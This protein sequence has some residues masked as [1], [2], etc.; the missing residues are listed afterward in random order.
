MQHVTEV[1]IVKEVIGK[2]ECDK[3]H[4]IFDKDKDIFEFQ[5]FHRAS[6]VGGYSSVFGDGSQVEFDL[7]QVC[8]L[9]ML[10]HFGVKYRV[11]DLGWWG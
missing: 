10:E 11:T 8:L 6:F 3:C 7:C 5:E 1:P 4:K 2:I 9:E